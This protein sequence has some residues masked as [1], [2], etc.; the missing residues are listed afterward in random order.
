MLRAITNR[1]VTEK[2]I[3]IPHEKP[4][5]KPSA[6]GKDLEIIDLNSL[7]NKDVREIGAEWLS[8]QAIEQLRS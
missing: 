8:Y 5:K 7:R 4:R 2:R 1:L 3:D 6:K